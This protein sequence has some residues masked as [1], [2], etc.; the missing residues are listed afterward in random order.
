MDARL[1]CLGLTGEQ[2]AG[3]GTTVGAI[4]R[5]HRIRMLAAM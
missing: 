4:R 3:F 1:S 2:N 5:F